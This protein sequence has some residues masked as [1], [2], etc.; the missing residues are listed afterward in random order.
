VP[1]D[2]YVSILTGGPAGGAGASA[3]DQCCLGGGGG[4]AVQLSAGTRISIG[5]AGSINASGGGGIANQSVNAC[6][7]NGGGGGGAGGAVVL[8][9]PTLDVSGAI[10]ANGGGGGGGE[11]IVGNTIGAMANGQDGSISICPALGGMGNVAGGEGACLGTAAAG[12][13]AGA[14]ANTGGA[15]GGGGAGHVV[16]RSHGAPQITGSISPSPVI[17]CN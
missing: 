8:E 13:P 3:T 6:L 17:R 12:A 7:H 5:L 14:P 4:G 15:G 9:S 10:A 1:E 16:L 2:V 11:S